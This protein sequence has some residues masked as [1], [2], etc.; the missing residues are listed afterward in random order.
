MD[1]NQAAALRRERRRLIER[2]GL[3]GEAR[4]AAAVARRADAA[5]LDALELITLHVG[6][7]AVG[8]STAGL[9]QRRWAHAVALLRLAGLA[10]GRYTRLT[11][12]ATPTATL[13]ALH[14]AH[15]LA[16]AQPGRWAAQMPRF[17]RPEVLQRGDSGAAGL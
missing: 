15:A 14:A 5:Y 1:A 3:A 11:L 16:V 13:H 6:G 9:P 8:R 4:R 7:G 12:C 10:Q 17:A 2:A